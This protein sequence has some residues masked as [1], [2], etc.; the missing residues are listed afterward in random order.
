VTVVALLTALAVPVPGTTSAADP[1]VT[2][3]SPG[4][5]AVTD[6]V[7]TPADLQAQRRKL[8]ELRQTVQEQTDEL[9]RA[10]ADLEAAALEA[11]TALEAYTTAVRASQQAQAVED[12]ERRLLLEARL[13]LAQNRRELGRWARQ[14]YQGGAAYEEH[15]AVVTLLGARSTDEAATTLAL[16]R[17]V[18]RAKG[19]AVN[20]V[21]AAERRQNVATTRAGSAASAAA[22]AQS[23]AA[24]A[25]QARDEAVARQRGKVATLE[26]AL[27]STTQEAAEAEAEE[28]RLRE[29]AELAR[30]LR[31]SGGPGGNA[32]TGEVG[33]CTGGDVALY[34]NGE[35][36]LEALCP[37][38]AAPGHRLRADAAFAFDKLAGEYAR[39]FGRL[40]CVS[41][42]Y[43][44][45]PSQVSLR[46]RK[47]GLAA[48]PGTSNHGWGTAVDLCGGIESFG[49]P[50][51]EWLVV[52]GPMFGWYHPSWAQ[53]GGSKPEPWHFE[54]GG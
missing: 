33:D 31:E 18:G 50:Q 36:P 38:A 45:Y 30:R 7:P 32:V 25:K 48:V 34:L 15:P 9:S 14:A 4:G 26:T 12:R 2:V 22:A 3:T 21:E 23:A 29:A 6:G 46:A 1:A 47:P 5:Y 8:D 11:A 16:L 37:L 27:R 41:D 39:T 42:S 49:T 24:E 17:G 52:N 10:T 44:D 51:H 28:R 19:R 20:A 53:A 35:I 13:E 43:R 54:Y 40:P